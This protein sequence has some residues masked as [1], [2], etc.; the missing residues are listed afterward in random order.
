MNLDKQI[1]SLLCYRYTI[2]QAISR[3]LAASPMGSK[4]T[5]VY[6]LASQNGGG[7]HFHYTNEYK[8]P[9]G[10]MGRIGGAAV[11]GASGHE[12]NKTLK[13]LK[14]LVESKIGR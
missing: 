6:E 14:R 5:V 13:R 2:P 3:I 7:T 8:L 1:Q 12:A 11:V 10:I 4:A 9:G